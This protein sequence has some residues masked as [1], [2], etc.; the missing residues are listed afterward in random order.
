M[1]YPFFGIFKKRYLSQVKLLVSLFIIV[2]ISCSFLTISLAGEDPVWEDTFS[3]VDNSRWQWDYNEGTGYK[4]LAIID[5]VSV[6]E[7]GIKDNS[8]SSEYSDC[9]L[10]ERSYQYNYGIFEA[11]LKCTDNNTLGNG[12]GTR[13]WG[14]W[15]YNNGLN[16]S[17]FWSLSP[18]SADY[19][20]GFKA[21]VI[22][23]SQF[24]LEFEEDLSEIDMKQWHVYRMEFLPTYTKFIVDEIEVASTTERPDEPQRFEFWID[25]ARISFIDNQWYRDY[26]D[27]NQEQKM[28]IDWVRYYNGDSDDDGIYD[29]TDNCPGDSNSDQV[30][31]DA[32]G[33]GDVC[34]NCPDNYNPSQ[35]DFDSDGFGDA[36][37]NCLNTFNPG[38]QDI[39][40]DAAG[41]A[42]DDDTLFGYVSGDILEDVFIDIKRYS[43]CGFTDDVGTVL[44]DSEG[45]YAYPV[46][47][48][49]GDGYIV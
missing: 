7:L 20:E 15:N 32:D 43:P 45:Y 24:P 31:T 37:D 39:D 16:S 17:W 2:T 44:T 13:G 38:Q 26:L 49:G 3:S 34:D 35:T 46:T 41:D 5:G 10:H 4:E 23:D 22:R 6:V 18:E 21:V 47:F 25:N 48:R 42:C 9:S 12:Q 30:D 28:Y 8:T 29:D 33:V 19:L 11:R 36:C 14:F 40:N 27:V 1:Q